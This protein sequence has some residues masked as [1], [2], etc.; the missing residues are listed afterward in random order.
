[1][2]GVEP[3]GLPRTTLIAAHAR[4]SRVIGDGPNI[5]WHSREDFAHFKA[6]TMGHVLVMGR[7][8]FESIGRPLPG[9]DTIVL[10]HDSSW[11]APGVRTASSPLHAYDMALVDC[12]GDLFVAGGGQVYAAFEPYADRQVVS[13][14]DVDVTGDVFYPAIDP[15]RWALTESQRMEAAPSFTVETW[16]R[17][18]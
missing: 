15:G 10:T 5:P 6:T 18:R 16:L 1:M 2:P 14:V 3:V 4:G 12:A 17:R 11:S 9:R 7:T 8:T 13:V